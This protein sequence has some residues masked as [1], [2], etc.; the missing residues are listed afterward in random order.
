MFT[1]KNT[2]CGI[3]AFDYSYLNSAVDFYVIQTINYRTCEHNTIMKRTCTIGDMVNNYLIYL[4]NNLNK[5]Y[6]YEYN[7]AMKYFKHFLRG[8]F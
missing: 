8:H 6:N 7:V 4:F 2:N 3:L 5:H 1:F